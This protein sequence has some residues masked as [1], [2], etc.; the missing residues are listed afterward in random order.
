MNTIFYVYRAGKIEKAVLP[1][2]YENVEQYLNEIQ[3]IGCL[4]FSIWGFSEKECYNKT[5]SFLFEEFE[6][7]IISFNTAVKR[8]LSDINEF[9]NKYIA[10]N[11]EPFKK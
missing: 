10:T 4:N 3:K 5:I 8:Q 2:G 9:I 1:N 7:L 11:E 6:N